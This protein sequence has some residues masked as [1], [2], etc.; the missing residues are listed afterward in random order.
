MK[1]DHVIG[2]GFSRW[3]PPDVANPDSAYTPGQLE[4]LRDY[5]NS[6]ILLSGAYR[7]GK[8]ELGARLVLRHAM[9]FDRAKVGVF[10]QHLANIKNSTLL[11][12]LQLT[13]PSWVADWSN[14]DLVMRLK[15]GSTISF[16]GCEFADRI[17]S[18]E[19]TFAFLDEAH[20]INSESR[21]MI[22]GRLSG[23]LELKDKSYFMDPHGDINEELWKYASSTVGL[24]QVFL[25]CNPKSKGHPLF[26][27]FIESPKPNHIAYNSNS[28]SNHFLP[29]VYIL[30]N[31]AAYV[32]D[33][34]KYGVDWI[35]E[36]IRAVR[37]GEKPTD[38]L[39][40]ESALTP[41]GQR[42]LLGLWRSLEGGVWP[43]FEEERHF[44]PECPWGHIEEHIGAVDWG[45]QNPRIVVASSHRDPE[46]EDNE[47]LFV[48]DYWSKK[49]SSPT[50]MIKA[51][52]RLQ[53]AYGVEAWYL[54]PDQPGLIKMA[55]ETLGAGVVKRAKNPVMPGI[56]AVSRRF[57][58]NTLKFLSSGTEDQITCAKEI[59]GYQWKEDPKG[60]FK[61]EPLKEADH[62]PDAIR[63]LVYSRDHLR[64]ILKEEPSEDDDLPVWP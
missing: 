28:I 61:D 2:T 39:F 62:Y 60:G 48:K 43:Q 8:S 59:A 52:K 34:A 27:D 30:N 54:P 41:F 56:D 10:R 64:S 14:G 17:G 6:F 42:N 13:H 36:Q 53:D 44:I 4:A 32:R 58:R 25:A 3:S 51:M 45:F 50:E 33:G 11:T 23:A 22:A 21:G 5:S 55:R 63:Y 26:Q 35:R 19:L 40:L 31:L 1:Y 47:L 18:I 15:N 38:G 57:S 7:S 9:T 24:R 12:V 46:D 49:E 37:A 20:E 16:L 29:E